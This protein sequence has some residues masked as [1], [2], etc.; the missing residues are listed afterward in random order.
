MS[1]ATTII[2]KYDLESKNILTNKGEI[3]A[4]FVCTIPTFHEWGYYGFFQPS[5]DEVLIR[6]PNNVTNTND[7]YFVTTKIPHP[8]INNTCI[9]DFHVGATTIWRVVNYV[10]C[11]VAPQQVQPTHNDYNEEQCMICME[12]QPNTMVMPCCHIVV[13]D[14]CS[15]NLQTTGDANICVKCRRPI[16]EVIYP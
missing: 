13:C 8:E 7:K 6:L 15:R 5:L 4:Q 2:G 10:E 9:G 14:K 16:T 1:N 3:C 11:N 12:H